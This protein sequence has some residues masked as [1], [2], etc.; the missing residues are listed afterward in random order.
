MWAEHL[1]F[2]DNS[3]DLVIANHML[4][5][6]TNLGQALHEIRRVLKPQG[7]F[8]A[9]TNSRNHQRELKD[10]LL[11]FDPEC[12]FPKGLT[13]RFSLENGE[14]ILS[15]EFSRIEMHTFTNC[16]K[17]PAVQPITRYLLSIFDGLKYSDL[18]P[19]VQGL[20]QHLQTKMQDGIFTLTGRSGIFV[21]QS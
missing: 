5:H 19:R 16:L 18:R 13:K 6:V 11:E 10:A 8:L 15:K 1:Q 7:K 12:E 3:F 4:Y 17:I 9:T 2:K 20:E 21:C 14:Q